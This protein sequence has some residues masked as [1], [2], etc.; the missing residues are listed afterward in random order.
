MITVYAETH[1]KLKNMLC[2]QSAGSLIVKS[3]STQLQL[4]FE[5]VIAFIFPFPHP[6]PH[7]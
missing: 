5:E 4:G 2:G 6:S 1:M 3:G 7:M